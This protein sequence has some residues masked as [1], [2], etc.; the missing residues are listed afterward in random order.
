MLRAKALVDLKLLLGALLLARPDIS[1]PESVARDSQIRIVFNRQQ[2][3]RDSRGMLALIRGKIS[4]L[5]VRLRELQI[6]RNRLLQQRFDLLDI[7]V[8][9]LGTPFLSP[10]H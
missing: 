6:E 5:Q 2:I 7:R 4:Q 3:L 9:I 10:T 1:L 8:S